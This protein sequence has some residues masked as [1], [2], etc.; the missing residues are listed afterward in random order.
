MRRAVLMSLSLV[1][2]IPAN[3]G[4]AGE[5]LTGR[6]SI[7]DGDTLRLRGKVIGLHGM[8]AP[9][10]DQ[11]C[12]D[13]K[14]RE[15]DCG[16]AAARALTTHTASAAISCTTRDTDKHG[17]VLAVCHKDK[18]DLSAWM[19]RRGYAV[20]DKRA[21]PS[22]VA[23]EARA[24]GRRRNLW[25]GVFEDP[26]RRKRTTPTPVNAVA[27]VQPEAGAAGIR[28]VKRETAGR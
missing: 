12:L 6:P 24:W 17:R 19:V 21:Q 4:W 7:I 1:A 13:T 2:C 22:Y 9:G 15:Y 3:W 14:A 26:T 10:K 18:E 5:T 28:T 8:A 16:Q 20:A 25:A 11:T 27:D 23:E